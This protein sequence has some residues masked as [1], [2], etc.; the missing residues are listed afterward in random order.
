MRKITIILTMVVGLAV[1][2]TAK[3]TLIVRGTG[4]ITVGTIAEKAGLFNLIYDNDLNITWLDYTK[5]YLD[6]SD[7]SNTQQNLIGWAAAL[8]VDFGGTIFSN[9]R[10]PS[11]PIT[12]PLGDRFN[13]DGTTSLGFNVTSSE[14]GHLFYTELGNM[15]ARDTSNNS[16]PNPGLINTGPFQNLINNQYAPGT[17]FPDPN[18]SWGFNF[19]NGIQSK[20]GLST[21]IFALAVHFGDVANPSSTNPIPEPSTMLLLATGLAG[22]TAW[23]RKSHSS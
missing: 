15:G 2:G 14:M 11:A 3:A 9:W 16:V 13:F 17:L 4:T 12:D 5:S 22:L 8:S 7:N 21:A 23:R 10:L 20:E 6:F 18:F 19:T 1:A